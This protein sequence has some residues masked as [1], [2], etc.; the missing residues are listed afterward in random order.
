MA[1][2]YLSIFVFISHRLSVVGLRPSSS[3]STGFVV[4]VRGDWA[5]FSYIIILVKILY[6]SPEP[7]FIRFLPIFKEEKA[8]LR[9]SQSENRLVWQYHKRRVRAHLFIFQ[10][11]FRGGVLLIVIISPRSSQYILY[12]RGRRRSLIRAL[13]AV[14]TKHR[15]K[16]RIVGVMVPCKDDSQLHPM[17]LC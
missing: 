8:N 1:F 6:S 16:I 14:R 17:P 11:R 10:R 15:E 13:C 3:L 2:V 12:T 9:P 7:I 5:I 4:T